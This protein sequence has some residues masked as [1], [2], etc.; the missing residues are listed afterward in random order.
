MEHWGIVYDIAIPTLIAQFLDSHSMSF[1]GPLCN[2]HDNVPSGKR[3]HTDVKSA[4]V[5]GKFS[6]SM[7][8]VNSYFD[9]FDIT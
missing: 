3:L 6:I 9:I 4:V 8:I 7:A 5:L 1:I 2:L